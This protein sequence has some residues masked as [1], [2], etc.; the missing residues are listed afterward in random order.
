MTVDI[1]NS[2]FDVVINSDESV[3]VSVR[4]RAMTSPLS[5]QARAPVLGNGGCLLP[6]LV[7]DTVPIRTAV[8]D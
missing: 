3:A 5:D 2:W 4:Q 7:L 8:L 6:N 1:K